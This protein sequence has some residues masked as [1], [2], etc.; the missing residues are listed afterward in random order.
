MEDNNSHATVKKKSVKAKVIGY[1]IYFAFLTTILL[2]FLAQVGVFGSSTQTEDTE[3]LNE[4]QNEKVI[5]DNTISKTPK[6][7]DDDATKSEKISK[8]S[9]TETSEKTLHNDPQPVLMPIKKL[10]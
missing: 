10:K 9:K 3:F 8:P 5:N 4:K 2:I 7:E 6:I 1:L